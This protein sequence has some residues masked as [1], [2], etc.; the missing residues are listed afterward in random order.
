MCSSPQALSVLDRAKERSKQGRV[1]KSKAHFFA[2]ATPVVFRSCKQ[3]GPWLK[4]LLQL[5]NKEASSFN[6][7]ESHP[8]SGTP[9]WSRRKFKTHKS[10]PKRQSARTTT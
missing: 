3:L 5:W 2:T 7:P 10:C 1:S 4:R 9:R 6:C 8:N